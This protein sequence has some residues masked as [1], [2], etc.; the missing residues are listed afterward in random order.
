M[1]E[2]HIHPVSL[3]SYTKEELLQL[4]DKQGIITS[5]AVQELVEMDKRKQA[6]EQHNYSIFQ[7]TNGRWYTYLPDDTKKNGRKQI[8]KSTKEKV[9]DAVVEFYRKINEEQTMTFK[10]MF[11]H[12]VEIQKT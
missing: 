2:R 7:G 4:L 10:K 11:L 12:W 6:L 1:T 5:D 9:E 3:L 8:V